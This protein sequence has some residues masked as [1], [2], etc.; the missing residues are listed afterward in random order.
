[1]TNQTLPRD[2]SVDW[3]SSIPFLL[4]HVSLVSLFWVGF[5]WAALALA[6][7]FYVVRMFAITGFYHRYFSHKTFKTSRWFQ[8]VMGVAGSSAVQKGPIWWAAHHRHH[9]AHSDDEHDVHSPRRL[10]FWMSHVGWIMTTESLDPPSRYVKDL[11]SCPELA[12]LDRFYLVVPILFG[13]FVLGLGFVI[14]RFFPSW[15]ASAGQV[16]VWGFLVSTI[17]LYH[18]TYT[19]NSLSHKFGRQRFRTGDDSRNN[20]WLALL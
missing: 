1:M 20:F 2:R 10:G 12:F 19:I 17:A 18:G 15:G 14:E 5:S 13:A 3:G 7:L 9:H 16:F 8:F 11:R 4:M 6:V